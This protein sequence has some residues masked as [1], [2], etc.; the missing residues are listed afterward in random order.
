MT[1]HE[2]GPRVRSVNPREF[3]TAGQTPPRKKIGKPRTL[4]PTQV[5]ELAAWLKARR[6]LGN[7]KSKAAEL[8]VSTGTLGLYL[9]RI[10][11]GDARGRGES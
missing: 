2:R 7:N 4:T 9:T 8:G 5:L 1:N 3:T 11:R 10:K 6:A